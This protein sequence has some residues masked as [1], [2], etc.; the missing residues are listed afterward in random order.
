MI[1]RALVITTLGTSL[2]L[3][4]CES[5]IL[6]PQP[7]AFHPRALAVQGS[8]DLSPSAATTG[9]INISD[10]ASLLRSSGW[11]SYQGGMRTY[12]ARWV[13]IC[14]QTFV[15]V[16][17]VVTVLG[18]GDACPC[19]VLN[20]INPPPHPPAT[21]PG[22]PG[23]IWTPFDSRP[24][25]TTLTQEFR[26][27]MGAGRPPNIV[28]EVY[29]GEYD[30][31]RFYFERYRPCPAAPTFAE[32][33][34]AAGKSLDGIARIDV[35]DDIPSLDCYGITKAE[36]TVVAPCPEGSLYAY[37]L[38]NINPETDLNG[39]PLGAFYLGI[40]TLGTVEPDINDVAR[41]RQRRAVFNGPTDPE[42]P[43][44][45][46]GGT[47]TVTANFI[48]SS[49]DSFSE[50]YFTV[51]ELSGDAC[52]CFLLSAD[53][54]S[55]GGVGSRSSVPASTFPGDG[56]WSPPTGRRPGEE[57][58]HTFRI[59][60]TRQARFTFLVDLH[61]TVVQPSFTAADIQ[62]IHRKYTALTALAPVLNERT[63]G[64][65]ATTEARGIGRRGFALVE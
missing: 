12:T 57:F 19:V 61:G 65:L 14:P 34:E 29:A 40:I 45:S 25:G 21:V 10:C 22:P 32:I 39:E 37:C 30:P 11:S 55:P 36:D 1:R 27:S 60:V 64:P 38:E 42:A 59:G 56:L 7:Q 63:R 44:R 43:E 4:G 9:P 52:P 54:G 20:S 5:E 15:N 6:D 16:S 46:L 62:T 17:F 51:E 23:F 58:T 35:I 53:I 47:V 24:P 18:G 2:L 28:I 3:V 41:N 48:N 33:V 8:T 13:N 31:S 49:S 50:V 26:V